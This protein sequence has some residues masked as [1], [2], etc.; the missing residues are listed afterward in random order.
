MTSSKDNPDQI[1]K[2]NNYVKT[3]FDPIYRNI[4]VQFGVKQTY[5]YLVI[6]TSKLFDNMDMAQLSYLLEAPLNKRL[7]G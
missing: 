4:I 6:S 2:S 7:A 5:F 1:E 3:S